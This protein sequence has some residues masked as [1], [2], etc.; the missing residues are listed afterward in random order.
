MPLIVAS[1]LQGQDV[2]K[3]SATDARVF[4]LKLLKEARK[5]KW[6]NLEIQ[7]NNKKQINQ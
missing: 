6:T 2:Q 1:T 4:L 7:F 5:L 3:I